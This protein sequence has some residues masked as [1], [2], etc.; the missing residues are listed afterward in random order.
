MVSSQHQTENLLQVINANY[1][2]TRESSVGMRSQYW[3]NFILRKGNFIDDAASWMN[4]RRNGVT[5]G[6][7][8]ANI[9]HVDSGTHHALTR[10]LYARV[11]KQVPEIYWP[12]FEESGVGNPFTVRIDGREVSRSTIELVLMLTHI[13]P[14]LEHASVVVEIGGG[15]GGL[16]RIVKL[17]FPSVKYVV[18]DLPEINAIQTYFLRRCFPNSSFVYATDV[19]DLSTIDPQE[20]NA[21]FTIIPGTFMR[22]FKSGCLDCAINARSMME[23]DLET[24]AFYFECLHRQLKTEGAFYCLNRY[25]KKTRLKDYPFDERWSVQRSVPWSRLIDYNRHHELIAVRKDYRVVD[26]VREL[27]KTLPPS[28]HPVVKTARLLFTSLPRPVKQLCAKLESRWAL[29]MRS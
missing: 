20:L 21:D 19:A 16:A 7:D 4:M 23:M 2:A 18:V 10:R 27:L 22:R 3:E 15:Y 28:D 9:S 14:Q 17:A 29:W 24:V 25:K 11:K 5:L 26:G 6:L 1:A 8:N 12:L 13:A